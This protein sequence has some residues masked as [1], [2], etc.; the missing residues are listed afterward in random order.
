MSG[1]AGSTAFIE[2]HPRLMKQTVLEV[3]LEHIA[4]RATI[5][6]G[7]I[8]VTNQPE[9]RWWFTTDRPDLRQ[10]V[11]GACQPNTWIATSSFLR[12]ASS[13]VLHP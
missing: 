5:S 9:T 8:D 11:V 2:R 10:L 13:A 3:H 1:A 7:R 12:S 6:N 4:R